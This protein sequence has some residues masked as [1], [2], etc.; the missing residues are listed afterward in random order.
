[1]NV[2]LEIQRFVDTGFTET[3][4]NH[5]IH[6]KMPEETEARQ[7]IHDILHTPSTPQV[8]LKTS[9]Q[10]DNT[11]VLSYGVEPNET[12]RI[13]SSKLRFQKY[14][15]KLLF[16]GTIVAETPYSFLQRGSKITETSTL[17]YTKLDI[18][19]QIV[20]FLRSCDTPY[21]SIDI[22]STQTFVT[23]TTNGEDKASIYIEDFNGLD[24]SILF[25][26][27]CDEDVDQQ[28]L[29]GELY[30]AAILFVH[31]HDFT[32]V[33]GGPT[34][35]KNTAIQNVYVGES[36]YC[37]LSDAEELYWN[38]LNH[39]NSTE[40]QLPLGSHFDAFHML[41]AMRKAV[42]SRYIVGIIEKA[43]ILRRQKIYANKPDTAHA[44]IND[45][46]LDAIT[47]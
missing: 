34:D 21:D 12:Q 17:L 15:D 11:N 19:K 22:A 45:D 5:T 33:V 9:R 8:P 1:M 16:V 39:Y 29:Y 2:P 47:S 30:E 35:R 36:E 44:L 31:M 25:D 40:P 13:R 46:I 14:D 28:S 24:L 4:E 32:N 10:Y 18:L 43:I 27:V 41:E 42:D 37:S 23:L 38:I 3:I 7:T 26:I 20:V 6:I